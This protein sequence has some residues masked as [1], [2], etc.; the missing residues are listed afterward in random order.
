M[1]SGKAIEGKYKMTEQEQEPGFTEEQWEQIARHI[2]GESTEAEKQAIESWMAEAPG[3]Q[4]TV[5]TYQEIWSTPLRVPPPSDI[6][7]L[8]HDIRNQAGIETAEPTP[9]R[10][11][12]RTWLS[13]RYLRYAAVILLV[14]LLP[15]IWQY[16]KTIMTP[17]IN[18]IRVQVSRGQQKQMTLPDGSR[19][20]LDAGTEL[21]YAENF[22]NQRRIK[23]SGEA[24]FEVH[25]NPDRPF[26]VQAGTGEIRVLGTS[27]NIRAWKREEA[28]EVVVREGRVSFAR[29]NMETDTAP[30]VIILANQFSRLNRKSPPSMPKDVD[31]SR[32]LG[33]IDQD[34][35]FDRIRLSELLFQIERWYDIRFETGPGIDLSEELSFHLRKKALTEV[36]VM[37]TTLVNIQYRIDGK[38]VHLYR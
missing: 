18:W 19:I 17:E 20:R 24:F 30:P 12:G 4:K 27:F 26:S 15:F 36:L 10:S 25:P 29:V 6:D 5:K 32:Y 38:T 28:V 9:V 7:R 11:I 1:D 34:Q 3:H 13:E 8:W 37:V 21:S 2:A 22:R 33:W 14:I 35:V 16:L 31:I 23:L